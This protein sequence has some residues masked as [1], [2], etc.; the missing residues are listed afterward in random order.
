MTNNG[1]HIPVAQGGIEGK[2]RSRKESFLGLRISG[3]TE[4]VMERFEDRTAVSDACALTGGEQLLKPLG[5]DDVAVMDLLPILRADGK[6]YGAF[7]QELIVLTG[8][9]PTAG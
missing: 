3:Q 7:S 2:G 8:D 6:G 1:L 9:R 5:P 4:I